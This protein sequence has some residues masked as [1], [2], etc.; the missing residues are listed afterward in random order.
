LKSIEGRSSESWAAS[1]V[2]PLSSQQP[3][4]FGVIRVSDEEAK[5]TYARAPSA[6]WGNMFHFWNARAIHVREITFL[7]AIQIVTLIPHLLAKHFI[8]VHRS[9]QS[10]QIISDRFPC[11][12]KLYHPSLTPW[13]VVLQVFHRPDQT[14]IWFTNCIIPRTRSGLGAIQNNQSRHYLRWPLETLK[15]W[16]PGRENWERSDANQGASHGLQASF[17]SGMNY[18]NFGR[19]RMSFDCSAMSYFAWKWLHVFRTGISWWISN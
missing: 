6:M 8:G 3:F 13:S 4:K 19:A 1:S 11:Q 17:H 10:H 14:Q 12:R 2:K 9:I 16:I 15:Y 5:V 18:R 7:N